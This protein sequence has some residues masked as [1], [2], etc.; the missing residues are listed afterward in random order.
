VHWLNGSF[1]VEMVSAGSS[2]GCVV[3]ATKRRIIANAS[4][5]FGQASTKKISTPYGEL[6][7]LEKHTSLMQNALSKHVPVY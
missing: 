4:I 5:G 6:I 3:N 7:F 1:I 2:L